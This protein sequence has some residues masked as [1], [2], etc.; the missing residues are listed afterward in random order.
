MKL[1]QIFLNR[2]KIEKIFVIE[3]LGN[4]FEISYKSYHKKLFFIN[5]TFSINNFQK[6]KEEFHQNTKK[7]KLLQNM[8]YPSSL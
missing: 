5:Y 2:F 3:I 1:K 6:T 7:S 4:K 8:L